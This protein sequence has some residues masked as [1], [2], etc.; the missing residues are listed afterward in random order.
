MHTYI[1]NVTTL[2]AMYVY[3]WCVNL[4]TNDVDDNY[5][6]GFWKAERNVMFGQLHFLG[7]GNSHTYTLP[8]HCCITRLS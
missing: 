2:E 4:S 7:P 1:H 8:V 5:V 6:T 3:A